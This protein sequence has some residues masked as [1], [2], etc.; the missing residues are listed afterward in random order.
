M[1]NTRPRNTKWWTENEHNKFLEL[2]PELQRNWKLYTIHLPNRTV[3]QIRSHAQKYFLGV[4][5][6]PEYKMYSGVKKRKC[7][8]STSSS[9][10]YVP[11]MKK[12]LVKKK[13]KS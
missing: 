13:K 9:S 8:G 1:T 10:A 11:I 4:E 6:D 3:P 7:G 2:F 5:R 12:V